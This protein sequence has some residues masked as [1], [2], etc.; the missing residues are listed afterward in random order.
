MIEQRRSVSSQGYGFRED[1]SEEEV[2]KHCCR[3]WLSA[4]SPNH[5]GDGVWG[6]SVGLIWGSEREQYL[7][8][9]HGFP[10]PTLLGQ[11]RGKS[12]FRKGQVLFLSSDPQAWC[13]SPGQILQS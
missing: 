2:P 13:G 1:F 11:D 5:G 10:L 8:S 6:G 12:L 4:L 7:L 9:N 3:G